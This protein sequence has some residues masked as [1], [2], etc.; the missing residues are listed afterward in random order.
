MIIEYRHWSSKLLVQN[1]RRF[2]FQK[3]I[4]LQK[5]LGRIKLKHTIRLICVHYSGRTWQMYEKG[6]K[7]ILAPHR[8]MKD[9]R[10]TLI[11]E[12]EQT[13]AAICNNVYGFGIFGTNPLMKPFP[14]ECNH[15]CTALPNIFA[16]AFAGNRKNCLIKIA[17]A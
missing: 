14:N 17:G 12:H 11:A 9:G 8:N 7:K 6:T 3:E 15:S 1:L 10:I 13:K 4:A 2:R 16:Y 5:C